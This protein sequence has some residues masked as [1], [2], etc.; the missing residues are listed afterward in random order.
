VAEQEMIRG[1]DG[2]HWVGCEETHYDCAIAELRVA[3]EKVTKDADGWKWQ[4]DAIVGLL[5]T[6]EK[7]IKELEAFDIQNRETP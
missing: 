5:E 2:S 4:F 7:R 1:G 3:L 6:A